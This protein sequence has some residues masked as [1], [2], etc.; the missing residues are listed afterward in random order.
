MLNIK[1]SHFIPNQTHSFYKIKI[2][3]SPSFS[4]TPI[5]VFPSTE[6]KSGVMPYLSLTQLLKSVDVIQSSKYVCVN[7]TL[8]V[9]CSHPGIRMEY[10]YNSMAVIHRP[11]GK[12]ISQSFYF[13]FADVPRALD[14]GTVMQLHPLYLS[15]SQTVSLPDVSSCGF[16][17][18][19]PFAVKR[20]S[21]NVSSTF[22]YLWT[23]G[24]IWDEVIN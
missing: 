17:G 10:N 4:I 19:P 21:L 7:A 6:A 20:C 14:A 5:L 1:I 24:H 13:I 9:A 3:T 16:L 22:S 18:W 12:T 11:K 2:F 15:S 23:K 8:K